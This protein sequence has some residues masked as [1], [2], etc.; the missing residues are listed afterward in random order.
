MV[1]LSRIFVSYRREDTAYPSGWLFDKLAQHFGQDQVF[2]DIDSIDLGD[3]FVEVITAAVERCEV[4]LALIG[5]KW[6]TASDE[7]GHQ[8]L[9]NPTDFVR[10]EVEAAITRNIRII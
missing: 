5:K 6:L 10:L 7:D 3:D 8:R 9:D 4:L 2:K 1:A